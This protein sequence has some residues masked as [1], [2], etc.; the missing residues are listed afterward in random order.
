LIVSIVTPT[1]VESRSVSNDVNVVTQVTGGEGGERGER[2]TAFISTGNSMSEVKIGFP[3]GRGKRVP[4]TRCRQKQIAVRTIS[5][6]RNLP[7][8]SVS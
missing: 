1:G 7:G 8:E 3:T 6:E 4:R 5:E 2:E